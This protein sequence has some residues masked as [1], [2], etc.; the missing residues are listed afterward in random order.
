MPNAF[1]W[2]RKRFK[3]VYCDECKHRSK[4]TWFGHYDCLASSMTVD[5]STGSLLERPK[6]RIL[7]GYQY[8]K[9]VKYFSWCKRYESK[10][11]E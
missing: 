4:D 5:D 7:H 8:C 10:T 2:F 11:K 9:N 1:K 6:K 3:T